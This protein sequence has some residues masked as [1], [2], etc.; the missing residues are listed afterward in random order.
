MEFQMRM[1]GSPRL[2]DLIGR[3]TGGRLR[4]VNREAN[5]IIER[6]AGRSVDDV[7]DEVLAMMR[8]R[9]LK[10]VDPA[11]VRRAVAEAMRG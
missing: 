1:S 8:S 10:R 6:S 9:G 4:D 3:V 5:R 11:E 2:G 7:T